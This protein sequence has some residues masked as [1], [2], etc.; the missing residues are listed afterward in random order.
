MGVFYSIFSFVKLSTSFNHLEVNEKTIL[1]Q[2]FEDSIANC[3]EKIFLRTYFVSGL[4]E[5]C[6][7]MMWRMHNSLD[8]LQKICALN[9]RTGIGKYM[10]IRYSFIGMKNFKTENLDDLNKRAGIYPY[11]LLH[12]LNKSKE[13][14]DLD[15]SEREKLILEREKVLS[16][17]NNI[18]E[19]FFISFGIDDQDMIVV[20]EALK[21]EDLIDATAKL[22][23]M[24]TKSYTISDKPVF[25]CIGKDLREILDN[26][27]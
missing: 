13:W 18:I 24:K 8:Y 7:I 4:K 14:Y 1:K 20:R 5:D 23:T 11:L 21:I 15:E 10:E 2:E 17:Y 27:S 19:N 12:P 3:Q 22:K 16:K 25:L 9:M 26:L 6:D